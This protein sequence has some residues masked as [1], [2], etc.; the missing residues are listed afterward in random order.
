MHATRKSLTWRV[1]AFLLSVLLMT[2]SL[3]VSAFAEETSPFQGTSVTLADNLIVNFYVEVQDT[4]GAQMTFL[5]KDSG[6]KDHE[7][8]VP[9][10]QAEHVEGNLYKFTCELVPAQMNETVTA[11]L[12]DSG[13]TYVKTTSVRQYAQELF[14]YRQWDKLAANDIMLATLNYGA[15]A[16]KYFEYNAEN[17]ANDGYVKNPASTVPAAKSLGLTGEVDGISFYG[18]T[19]VFVSKVA[20]R[21]YFTGSVEGKTFKV[22]EKPYTPHQKGNLY[23]VEIPEINPQDYDKNI[24]LTVSK[25]AQEMSVT[26]SPMHYISRMYHKDS[27]SAA[28]KT[29]LSNL[30]EYHLQAVHYLGDLYGNA[31]DN[32]VSAQ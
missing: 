15:A 22:G 3:S 14:T 24:T 9:V 1:L 16:Q 23:Y 25:D 6:Y 13:N 2:G 4:D 12:S 19:L 32:L 18:G 30:Y 10:S 29:L 11:T 28:M 5:V 27:S 26:Y 20:V 7:E 17:P 8:T 31:E 21:F